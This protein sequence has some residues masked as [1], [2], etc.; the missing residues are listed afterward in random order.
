MHTLKKSLLFFIL[1]P[2][3]KSTNILLIKGGF[4]SSFV[5]KLR[6]EGNRDFPPWQSKK[7]RKPAEVIHY[8]LY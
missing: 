5:A 8:T 6:L 1:L 7:K 2:G 3:V 4:S